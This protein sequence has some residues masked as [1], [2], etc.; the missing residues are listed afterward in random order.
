MFCPAAY[1]DVHTDNNFNTLI[2]EENVHPHQKRTTERA[3]SDH[4]DHRVF[5]CYSKATTELLKPKRS[6]IGSG[7]AS[8]KTIRH[9][10]TPWSLIG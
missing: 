3:L 6:F 10:D 1:L 8:D 9:G 5:A 4:G 2:S 7:N